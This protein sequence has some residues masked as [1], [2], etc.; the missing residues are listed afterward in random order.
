MDMRPS[1][2]G[3]LLGGR[4]RGLREGRG[5]SVDE[6]AVR[7]G[8]SSQRI[9]ELERGGAPRPQKKDLW[10]SWGPQAT[11][12][13]AE[14]CRAAERVDLHA[15]LGVPP[16]Y[17]DLDAERCTAYVL[18][19]APTDRDDVTFRVIPDDAGA[20]PSIGQPLALFRLADAPAVV[21]YTYA[22]AVMFTEDPEHA[23]AA[24]FV[25]TRLRELTAV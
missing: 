25:F 19:D 12:I 10:C 18:P 23:D 1:L 22:H 5:L 24:D 21:C 8:L 9:R 6:L 17:R 11:A 15:P 3:R 14:L 4:L 16:V 13:L 2:Q 7:V 20:Y